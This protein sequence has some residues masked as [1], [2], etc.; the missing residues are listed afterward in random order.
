MPT[1]PLSAK[2]ARR[3][4]SA[5]AQAV[6]EG[7][8]LGEP[9]AVNQKSAVAEVARRLGL[10][11]RTVKK[12]LERGEELYG[13]TVD[14]IL[15]KRDPDEDDDLGDGLETLDRHAESNAE[16]ISKSRKKWRRIIPVKPEP[17]GI[18][19]FGDMHSD[20][21]GTD[22]EQLKSDLFLCAAAGVRCVNI[23]DTLDN[24][25]WTG[26]LAAKQAANRMSE[27]EG[28]EVARWII[29]DSGCIFD[30]HI[31]GNHD[32]WAG[33]PYAALFSE[34]ARQAAHPSRFYDWIVGL[35][36]QWEGGEYSLLAAHDFRGSSYINPLHSLFRRARED[37]TFDG[38][39]AGHRHNAA[40]GSFENAYRGKRYDYARVGS[41][42]KWD[43]YA[44]RSGFDQQV[45]GSSAMFVVNPLAEEMSGRCRVL[46]SISEGLEY[47]EMKRR[48]W[49]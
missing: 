45:E 14:G 13:L 8:Y 28:L 37:G 43:D 21:K 23:G 38:Y 9:E 12:H 24:F 22:L 30:A 27:K 18:A 16:Y 47:L 7:M 35:T 4:V 44:H 49:G 10:N 1:P 46:P 42:K 32:A 6:S 5:V 19:V 2:V 3:T 15:R 11:H 39:V 48:N 20:N 31:L 17:F 25:H 40:D 26:K 36:Y 29:R 34:W 33:G 41:Y